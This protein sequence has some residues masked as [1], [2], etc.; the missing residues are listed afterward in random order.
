MK[1]IEFI[2]KTEEEMIRLGEAIGKAVYPNIVLTMDGNLGAGKTTLTKGIGKALGIKR[3]INSPTFTIM[4]VYEGNMTLYH[5]DVYRIENSNSDFEL[6]EYFY[7]DGV[8]V[9]EWSENIKDLIPNDAI[10][11]TFEINEDASRKVTINGSSEFIQKLNV[12]E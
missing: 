12:G 10:R 9:I 7:L 2:I 3:V 11:L 6:E 8:T 5:L 1:K 4:K